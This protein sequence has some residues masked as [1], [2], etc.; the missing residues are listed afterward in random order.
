MSQLMEHFTYLH[1]IPERGME[2]FK[3]S[4][5]LADCL[6][7]AGYEVTR[8]VGGKTAASPVRCWDSGRTWM[9]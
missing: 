6:E 3:T 5:Y 4:A 9:P 7:K 1:T 2:E 8:N